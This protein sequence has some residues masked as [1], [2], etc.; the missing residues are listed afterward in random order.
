MPTLQ[1]L[2]QHRDGEFKSAGKRRTPKGFARFVALNVAK[3]LECGAFHRFSS[4][5]NEKNRENRC[6]YELKTL[7]S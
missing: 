3:R 1:D 4:N 7:A 6:F 2:R 5:T